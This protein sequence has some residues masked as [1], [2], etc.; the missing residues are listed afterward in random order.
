MRRWWNY[1]EDGTMNVV[2]N[3]PDRGADLSGTIMCGRV[4]IGNVNMDHK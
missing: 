2:A 3:L 4:V 1:N